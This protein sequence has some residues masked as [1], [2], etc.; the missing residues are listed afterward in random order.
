MSDP[1]A[2]EVEELLQFLYL[3]PIGI[4]KFRGDGTVDLINPM[5]NQLLM[6]LLAEPAIDNFFA[7]MVGLCHDLATK[8]AGFEEPA[9]TVMDQRRI[10]ARFGRHSV[11][12]S[13]TVT[14]VGPDT[15]M[16][17]LKDISRL[18]EM[19]GFA[20]ASADLLIDVEPDGTVAWASGAFQA[21]FGLAAR[22]VIGK[23]LAALVAPRDREAL[24]RALAMI[25]SR[26]RLPPLMLRLSNKAET[27]AVL[28][29]LALE[30]PAQRFFVTIGPPPVVHA[31]SGDAPLAAHAFGL[32][33]EAW[34]RSGQGGTLALLEVQDWSKTAANLDS[35][36][37]AVLK[38]EIRR[39]GVD[40]GD[41]MLVGEV[42]E[43]RF[44]ILA[45]TD[46]DLG[47]IATALRELLG[48]FVPGH[49]AQV[50]ETRIAMEQGEL[51]LNQSVQALRLVLARFGASAAGAAPGYGL[52]EGLVG[53][54][55]QASEHKRALA[56]IIAEGDFTMAYQPVVSLAD[57]TVHHYE[58]LLR[59]AT[60]PGNPA[61]N[62]GEFVTMVEAVGLAV[63]LDDAVLSKAVAALRL[64]DASVAVNLSGLSIADP[65]FVGRVLSAS[66]GLQPG[67]LLLE[68]TE[69]AEIVDLP[70]VAEQ[71]NRLRA[72]G[73][74]VCIDDFGAGNASFRYLR[75]LQVDCVKIDG[76]YVRAAT[77]NLQDRSF[78]AAMCDMAASSGATTIAEMIETEADATVMR[79]LG[80]GFGQGWLFGRPG[81]LPGRKPPELAVAISA[82]PQSASTAAPLTRWK[83]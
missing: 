63:A 7:S 46:A 35:Q 33:A 70:R 44:G 78:I 77:S 50:N 57:G 30:G 49:V 81:P 18:T 38:R 13:L 59:P 75:D 42:A 4:I 23:P 28:A 80:V 62:P 2:S 36:H 56:R 24:S 68:L 51:S 5:A 52:G 71:I 82:M 54:I 3:M 43:G 20:F 72:E 26:G 61:G 73:L 39:L 6:P 29:G 64:S 37:L 12:L 74:A 17:A 47:P 34:L 8:V 60:G 25:G 27:R 79:E 32:E 65:D 69:T 11:T 55:R 53:I 31:A 10:D 15:Y 41:D 66:K 14:R 1:A 22:E 58:A 40:G 16:A 76:A 21:L 48:S 9:G 83:Y 45:P 19:L 67:Q